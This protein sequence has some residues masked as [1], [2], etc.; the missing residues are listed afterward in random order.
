MADNNWTDTQRFDS[1]ASQWDANAVRAALADAVAR[2]IIAHLPVSRPEN[3]L[4]FGCGTGLVSLRVAP[5][6]GRLTAVD[7][8]E[9]M[10]GMLNEKITAENVPNVETRLLDLS[11][12]GAASNLGGSFDFVFSSMTL[13]HIPDTAAFL[14]LLY[15][16]M[17]AGGTLAIA[18]LDAE[19]GLFHDD[20][21]ENVHH[22]FDR[23]ALQALLEQAGFGSVSF[24]TA[25]LIEKKNREGQ[26]ASYPV[27]LATAVKPHI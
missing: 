15:S 22:G 19:D 16:H 3:A 8:S 11:L 21:T 24:L 25:H 1:K 5:R 2:A 26:I 10:L 23:Q 9:G 18:D 4:E 27:F 14:G 17:S 20:A 6:C 13:H 7:S 12:A